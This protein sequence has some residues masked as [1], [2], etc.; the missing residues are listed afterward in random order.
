L[1]NSTILWKR[2]GTRVRIFCV[3]LSIFF[4]IAGAALSRDQHD[5]GKRFHHKYGTMPGN[6]CYYF[7]VILFFSFFRFCFQT[8]CSNLWFQFRFRRWF[9][10]YL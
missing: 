6:C 10:R 3:G 2:S 4:F 9:K 7:C 1:W 5:S 8:Q